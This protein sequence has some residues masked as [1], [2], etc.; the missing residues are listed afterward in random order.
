MMRVLI[1]QR[2]LLRL[3]M[4]NNR[5][6]ISERLISL[7]MELLLIYLLQ[8]EL[9]RTVLVQW[10]TKMLEWSLIR[11]TISL[12]VWLL[13]CFITMIK[14][15]LMMPRSYST[16]RALFPLFTPTYSAKAIKSL[17]KL[18][19]EPQALL[20]TSDHLMASIKKCKLCVIFAGHQI[21]TR[22]IQGLGSTAQ[23]ANIL[24]PADLVRLALR[25]LIISHTA[26]E[27]YHGNIFQLIPE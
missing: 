12:R 27:D 24:R 26:R 14:R 11:Q 6:F 15:F 17:L 5:F 10:L 20:E 16:T 25:L 19:I 21:R 4:S 8:L 13:G 7:V 2:L 23:V 22:W 1:P 9:F 3:K 18:H